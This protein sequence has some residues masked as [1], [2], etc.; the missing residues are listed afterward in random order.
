MGEFEAAQ[1]RSNLFVVGS[2]PELRE[3]ERG[4]L[5]AIR[6]PAKPVFAEARSFPMLLLAL[7]LNGERSHILPMR[8]G[9][10]PRTGTAA[11]RRGHLD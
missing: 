2:V 11:D 10:P 4:Y 3:A 6:D 9:Y 7:S 1:G 5:A 8:S